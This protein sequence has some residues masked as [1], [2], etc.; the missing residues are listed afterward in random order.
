M[1]IDFHTRTEMVIQILTMAKGLFVGQII[2]VTAFLPLIGIETGTLVGD[3]L[4]E[5]TKRALTDSRSHRGDLIA[6]TPVSRGDSSISTADSAV[7]LGLAHVTKIISAFFSVSIHSNLVLVML[8][9]PRVTSTF[10]YMNLSAI[11][12]LVQ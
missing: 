4:A 11:K 7:W 8:A 3:F 9:K 6:A 1:R 2:L 12:P 10:T 5:H